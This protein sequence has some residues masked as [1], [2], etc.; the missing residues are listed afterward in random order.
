M[1]FEALSY[2]WT[3]G[4]PIAKRGQASNFHRHLTTGKLRL[5]EIKW[6]S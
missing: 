6:P 5:G 2:V 3:Y 4:I 1:V